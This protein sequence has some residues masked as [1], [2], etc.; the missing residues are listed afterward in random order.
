MSGAEPSPLAP[1]Q[2][3]GPSREPK[4]A[5][6]AVPVGAQDPRA[7]LEETQKNRLNLTQSKR[8]EQHMLGAER[9]LRAAGSVWKG[10]CLFP[11]DYYF[12]LIICSVRADK[13]SQSCIG[14]IKAMNR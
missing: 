9:E 4:P 1:E 5:P 14:G 8:D 13:F 3:R 10:V 6:R 11:Q 7:A 2:T 12:R